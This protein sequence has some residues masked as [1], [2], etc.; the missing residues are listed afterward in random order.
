LCKRAHVYHGGTMKRNDE[1]YDF[2]ARAAEKQA[3]RDEDECDL[4][5]GR[6]SVEQLCRENE[7]LAPLAGTARVE[8]SASR[9]LG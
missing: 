2:R 7:L 4:R 5:E 6:K 1:T 8:I 3:R 9:S